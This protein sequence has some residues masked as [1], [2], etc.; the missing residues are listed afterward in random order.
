M[1]L[2]SV[3]VLEPTN[4][5]NMVCDMCPQALQETVGD[6]DVAMAT[7]IVVEAGQSCKY[8]LCYFLGETTVRKD[9][10]EF[11]RSIRRETTAVIEVSTNVIRCQDKAVADAFLSS[12]VDII[13][14]C[15]E[16][17]TAE[18]H[19]H[20]RRTGDFDAI[21]EAVKYLGKESLQ[22]SRPVRVVAKCILNKANQHEADRFMEFWSAQPGI[23]PTVTW[24]NTWAGTMPSV[25]D[26]AIALCPNAYQERKP[27]AELWNKLVIR[28][29]GKVVACCH[30]WRNGIVLGDVTVNSLQEI[31]SGRVAEQLRREHVAG[32]FGGICAPCM[33]WSTPEEFEKDY[34]LSKELIVIPGSI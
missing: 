8:I 1:N 17:M 4:R 11:I 5:C 6:M 2:P 12:G 3:L 33:E 24:L 22:L 23:L 29:N 10:A 20:L 31:W 14:C 30:D 16:G 7:R 26:Y 27:C 25:L 13:V 28:W 18:S 15:V 21:V 9:F 32:N 34:G 19:R